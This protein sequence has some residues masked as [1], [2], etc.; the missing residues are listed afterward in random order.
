MGNALLHELERLEGMSLLV[1]DDDPEMVDW[2]R[3]LLD[4]G[5]ARVDTAAD[6]LQALEALARGERYDLIVTDVRMPAPSGL[7]L[8]AMART[9]GYST[10]FL[11][12]TAFPSDELAEKIL[13][14][15]RAALLAKPFAPRELVETAV[16]LI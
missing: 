10:P 11:V 9:A 2:L 7:Q 3:A 15:E 12:I 14:Q 16:S 1:V 4:L 6:G 13:A 5:K 8:L